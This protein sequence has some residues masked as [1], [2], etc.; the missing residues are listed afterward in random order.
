VPKLFH[1]IDSSTDSRTID[2]KKIYFR[3][4]IPAPPARPL[5][6][7]KTSPAPTLLRD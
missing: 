1:E 4:K 6:Y 5:P 3:K 2:G 7:Y